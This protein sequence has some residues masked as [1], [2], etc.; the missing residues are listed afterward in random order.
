M[1]EGT[2]ALRRDLDALG[3]RLRDAL[4]SGYFMQW[5]GFGGD[6][7]A[8]SATCVVSGQVRNSTVAEFRDVPIEFSVRLARAPD[9]LL[10]QISPDAAWGVASND[11]EL[12]LPIALK[13]IARLG[14]APSILPATEGRTFSVGDGF[15]QTLVDHHAVGTMRHS[16]STLGR[17][18][19]V[20]ADNSAIFERD[21]GEDR[22]A[23]GAGS[24]R[25][26]IGK[27]HEAL[28]LFFWEKPT[29]EI[30]FANVG[31]K[32]EL[33]VTAGDPAKAFQP[34]YQP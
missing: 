14:L 8:L 2:D 12:A 20:V 24:R 5:V 32:H 13:A 17:C 16:G 10:R 34:C 7:D 28:R 26:H 19:I 29:G 11:A 18:A 1:R 30:E 9:D 31:V 6:A 4:T 3:D 25:V 33:K 23:D 27:A 15:Y 21:F 22:K